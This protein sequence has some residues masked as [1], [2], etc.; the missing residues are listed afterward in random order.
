MIDSIVWAFRHT[1]RNVADVGLHLLLEMLQR[2]ADAGTFCTQFHRVYYRSL[3]HEVF[4]VLT[5]SFHKPGFKLHVKILHHLFS[6]VQEPGRITAPL[7]EGD[8]E[9]AAAVSAGT[10]AAPGNNTEYVRRYVGNLLSRSFPNMQPVQV[11]ACVEGMFTLRDYTA[12]KQHLRDFLV[13]TKEFADS[14][15]TEL[16][17]E[18]VKKAQQEAM[19][20]GGMPGLVPQ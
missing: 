8:E 6:L 2:F 12:F 3:V 14:D 19:N 15:N 1:E 5:D 16:F 10:A 17:V 13:Q 4:A 7:W 20:Q 9:L 18:E 11:A